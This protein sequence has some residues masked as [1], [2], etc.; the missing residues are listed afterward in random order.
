MLDEDKDRLLDILLNEDSCADVVARVVAR[1]RERERCKSIVANLPAGIPQRT[2]EWYNIRRGMITASEFKLAGSGKVCDSYIWGKV[3]PQPFP[4]NDAMQWGCRFEDLAAAVYEH[5]NRTKIKEFGL[6]VHPR[7]PWLGASPD[8]I[9]DYG[10]AIEIKCPYSRKRV[11]IDK[12]VAEDRP[13]PKSDR[14]NLYARYYPQVQGQLEICDLEACD[15]VV[16]CIDALDEDTFWQ[17]RRVSEQ[18]HRYAVVADIKRCDSDTLKY[19]TSPLDLDDAQMLAWEKGVQATGSA[20]AFHHVHVRELGVTRIMRDRDK[21]AE[22]YEGLAQS[23][24]TIEYIKKNAE[25]VGDLPPGC[26]APLFSAD[27]ASTDPPIQRRDADVLAPAASAPASLFQD[28][29]M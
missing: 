12:R 4:S 14:A 25:Q 22:I 11:E 10:V 18:T 2:T 17:V 21:W 20:V 29:D 23:K 3:F 26:A 8:G 15:F 9:T 28:E 16:A 1:S 6:L 27:A 7:E 13:F 5:E 24:R 19:E